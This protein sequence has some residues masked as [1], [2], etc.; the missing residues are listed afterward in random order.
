MTLAH[1]PRISIERENAI[2]IKTELAPQLA[3]TLPESVLLD[4]QRVLARW[5]LDNCV[6]LSLAGFDPPTPFRVFYKWH[7]T[8]YEHQ[9]RTAEFMTAHL[10]CGVF[11]QQGTGKTISTIASIDYLHARKRVR[12][13]LVVCPISVMHSAWVADAFTAAPHLRVAVAHGSREKRLAAIASDAEIVVINPDG[14]GLVVDALRKD[15][16]FD[17]IVIDEANCMKNVS[18]ARFRHVSKLIEPHTRVVL[19]TGTPASQSPMDAYGLARLLGT[20]PKYKQ[21]WEALTMIKLSNFKW[22]PK[23]DA[24]KHVQQVLTPAIRFTKAQ[25]LDL[26]PVTYIDRHAAMTK[27]QEKMYAQLQKEMRVVLDAGAEVVASNAGALLSKLMQ[28]SAGAVYNTDKSLTEFDISA[29][30]DALRE[31]IDGTD[32]KVLVFVNFRSSIQVLKAKL[33]ADG[34]EVGW[35]DGSVSARDRAALVFRFQNSPNPRVLL[36]QSMTVAHGVTLTAADTVVWWG[37]PTSVEIYKQAND[38]PHRIGQK[39]PVTVFHLTSSY[40]ERKVFS[41]LKANISVHERV[42]D[43]FTDIARN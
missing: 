18:T 7:V 28:I 23:E 38:R 32:E 24:H 16:R 31:I 17:M 26:P 22:Q 13:V 42:V 35:I 15:G 6:R 8:P 10:R 40:A 43:L 39:N 14:I 3:K 5:T 36:L 11:N 9:K 19:L 2:I 41:M 1:D 20:A 12:R 29:R 30:Y 27:D 21:D 4:E 33:E 37:P 25:C 34:Y